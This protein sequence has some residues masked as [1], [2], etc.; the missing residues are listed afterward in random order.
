MQPSARSSHA[1]RNQARAHLAGPAE[2]AGQDTIKGLRLLQ[3]GRMAA[4]R[5]EEELGPRDQ[6][7]KPM[8]DLGG[9]IRSSA[10]QMMQVG[11]PT[12]GKRASM[13]RCLAARAAWSRRSTDDRV[14]TARWTDSTHWVVTMA[15]L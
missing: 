12:V 10:P 13:L 5:E 14:V 11:A 7:V 2:P 1:S 6:G 3:H 4:A 8:R 15:G 9:V